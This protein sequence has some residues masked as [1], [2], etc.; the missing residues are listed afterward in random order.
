MR[1]LPASTRIGSSENM[2]VFGGCVIETTEVAKMRFLRQQTNQA[3]VRDFC[4][5]T[6]ASI[7]VLYGIW[8]ADGSNATTKIS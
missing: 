1:A 3:A 6:R 8:P 5:E 4:E 2:L 7:S